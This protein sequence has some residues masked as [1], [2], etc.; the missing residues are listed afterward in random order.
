M[1]IPIL[2]I[3]FP[4]K[5]EK[6][7]CNCNTRKILFEY[8][9]HFSIYS[10]NIDNNYCDVFFSSSVTSLIHAFSN[11]HL[12]TRTT[13]PST[14]KVEREMHH[15]SWETFTSQH[16]VTSRLYKQ[17]SSPWKHDSARVRYA[18][19]ITLENGANANEVSP[20]PP[21]LSRSIAGC[22][23]EID[24]TWAYDDWSGSAMELNGKV[25]FLRW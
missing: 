25:I 7:A 1:S 2:K 4:N 19:V 9:T 23:R 17:Q 14:K 24:G 6:L 3:L 12:S 15:R 8:Y 18:C 21:R 13:L 11:V 16:R 5:D 20:R 22:G 10:L